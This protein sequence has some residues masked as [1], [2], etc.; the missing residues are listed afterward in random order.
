MSKTASL[1]VRALLAGLSLC[2][3]TG[4]GD[5]GGPSPDASVAQEDALT[6]TLAGVGDPC[7]ADADCVAGLECFLGPEGARPWDG[8]YCTRPCEV[9]ADCPADTLCG[10][11]YF[12]AAGPVR[13]CLATCERFDGERG[14]CRD[15][16]QCYGEG[17]CIV[18]CTNDT[19]CIERDE[20]PPPRIAMDPSLACE[21]ESG[22]CLRAEPG[23]AAVGEPCSTNNDCAGPRG[24]C[25]LG[26]CQTADCDLGGR[27]ACP[28]GAV[29]RGLGIGDFALPV[30][31]PACT[32][33]DPSA[34]PLGT[35]CHPMEADFLGLAD[36]GFCT[37]VPTGG[38]NPTAT[39]DTPCTTT[40]DCPNPYGLVACVSG[41]CAGLY[42]AAPSVA[43]VPDI[44]P[45]G[46][47][48][49]TEEPPDDASR[50]QAR[51][52]QLGVCSP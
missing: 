2:A 3:V 51:A 32:V 27:F 29:C 8:G 10:F 7:A 33:E 39:M 13:R 35:G 31:V 4:C 23:T 17:A 47:I 20:D 49:R 1:R 40:A 46:G 44:C 21:I 19:Q 26:Q 52:L 42:C 22:R 38:T 11:A 14:G 30:C 37:L 16:Y 5:D 9:G 6:P 48:C 41:T 18:G 24:T 12:D 36:Q 34:C 25:N 43:E 28:A 50:Q 45:T 15:G